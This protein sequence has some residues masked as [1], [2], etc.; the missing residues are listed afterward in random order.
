MKSCAVFLFFLAAFQVVAHGQKLETSCLPAPITS[1][2]MWGGNEIIQVDLREHPMQKL[3]G[4]TLWPGDE[5]AYGVLLQ[6][7]KRGHT[8]PLY[9]PREQDTREPMAVCMTDTEGDFSFSLPPGEYELRASLNRGVD[10]TSVFVIVE[11]GLHRSPQI[12]VP[13]RSGS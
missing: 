1:Q 10:V 4:L 7:F 11:R 13:I 6:V 2:T 9:I 8:D 12:E 5:P 3:R